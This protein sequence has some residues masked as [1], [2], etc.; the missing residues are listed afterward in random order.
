MEIKQTRD[1]LS[2]TYLTALKIRQ[3][4]FVK[5]QGVPLGL[6]IDKNEA[7]AIHFVLFDN[8]K[9]LSTLRLLEINPETVLV[10]RVATPKDKRGL[11][12]GTLL[13]E[14]AIKFASDKNY[15]VIQ[16]HSQVS[17]QNFYEKMG[18]KA[19]GKPYMEASIEHINMR[20]SL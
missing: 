2:K 14:E 6:E 17:A 8:K 19:Y 9:A 11:G 13:L 20:K 4:V 10:Q 1:T 7:H 12:Y 15:K 5:E 16:L 3:E 18:F